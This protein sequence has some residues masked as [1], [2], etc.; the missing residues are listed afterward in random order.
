MMSSTE[1][2]PDAASRNERTARLRSAAI[3]PR[4]T[5]SAS[6]CVASRYRVTHVSFSSPTVTT[7]ASIQASD[8]II[9][10]IPLDDRSTPPSQTWSTSMNTRPGREAKT[11]RRDP[12]HPSSAASWGS[13]SARTT[14]R[15][16]ISP[17]S[18]AIISTPASSALGRKQSRDSGASALVEVRTGCQQPIQASQRWSISCAARVDSGPAASIMPAATKRA[19][20]IP[21]VRCFVM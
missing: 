13:P 2:R 12:L 15:A 7:C 19:E 14:S 20:P 3:S 16:A 11:A 4:P 17:S 5:A 8:E 6:L 1:Y 9:A 10:N 21:A 18:T